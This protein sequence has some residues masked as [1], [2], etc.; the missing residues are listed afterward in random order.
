MSSTFREHNDAH[1]GMVD[2]LEGHQDSQKWTAAAAILSLT[3][4]QS[5]VRLSAILY[6]PQISDSCRVIGCTAA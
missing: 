1:S 4:P 5:V 6:P 3:G 2:S